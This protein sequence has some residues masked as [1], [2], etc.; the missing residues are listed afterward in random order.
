MNKIEHKRNTTVTK[1]ENIR[2]MNKHKTKK[3]NK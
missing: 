2:K 1:M 3:N